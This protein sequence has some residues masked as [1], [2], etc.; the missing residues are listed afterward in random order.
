VLPLTTILQQM[1]TQ[2][3]RHFDKENKLLYIGISLSTFARLSQHKDH[4][5]WFKKINRVSI[6]HF[7]TREEAMAAERNAIK[8]ENPMFNIAMKKTMAEIAKEEKEKQAQLKLQQIAM[9]EAAK[10]EGKLVVERI[11]RYQLAYSIDEVMEIL[12]I[13]R[14][15]MAK[16]LSEGKISTFE[17][18]GRHTGRWQP[19]IKTMVSG[20]SL[21][22]FV[23]YLET[24]EKN[25]HHKQI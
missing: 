16:Y 15:E 10:K 12:N 7:E 22:D 17:V 18:L 3:Y 13:T 21:I 23:S 6:E 11:I 1:N 5:E 19:K 8:F 4:S 24:K 14:Q 9:K 20:W 2:L 25:D